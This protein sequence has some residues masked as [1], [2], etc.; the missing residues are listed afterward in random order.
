MR[1]S[2]WPHPARTAP[3][4]RANAIERGTRDAQD[5]DDAPAER[6]APPRWQSAIPV[7]RPRSGRD[8]DDAFE[9]NAGRRDGAELLREVPDADIDFERRER[10]RAPATRSSFGIAPASRSGP[11]AE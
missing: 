2:S 3:R 9:P 1:A 10:W 11:P 5:D 6:M 4:A 7:P 8:R